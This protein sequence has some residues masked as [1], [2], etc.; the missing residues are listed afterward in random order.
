MKLDVLWG[1][2]LHQTETYAS[3]LAQVCARF[4]RSSCFYRARISPEQMELH[5][6][7]LVLY[8]LDWIDRYPVHRHITRVDELV[9]DTARYQNRIPFCDGE[10]LAAEHKDA[11]AFS[12]ER[13]VFPFVGVI[14]TGLT[15]GMFYVEHHVTRNAIVWTE[16]GVRASLFVTYYGFH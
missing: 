4:V 3:G 10:F 13:L 15:W 7:W 6:R 5:C 9:S 1:K 2:H 11:C 12:D 8:R 16:Y 14:G